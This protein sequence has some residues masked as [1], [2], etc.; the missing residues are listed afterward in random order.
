MAFQLLPVQSLSILWAQESPLTLYRSSWER[1]RGERPRALRLSLP[2]T[3]EELCTSGPTFCNRLSS[4]PIVDYDKASVHSRNRRL[5]QCRLA[6][7][8]FPSGYRRCCHSKCPTNTRKKTTDALS[9]CHCPRPR[10]FLLVSFFSSGFLRHPVVWAPESLLRF[11]GEI[12]IVTLVVSTRLAE[13]LP[14]RH[15]NKNNCQLQVAFL[16]TTTANTTLILT[17][18]ELVQ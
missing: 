1:I 12:A 11:K 16:S 18:T 6:S 10:P 4:S 5:R 17:Y 13:L 7:R 2:G 9:Q 3:C 15:D 14:S 8:S